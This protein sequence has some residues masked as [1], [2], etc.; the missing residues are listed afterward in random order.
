[1]CLLYA[2]A[3]KTGASHWLPLMH[4]RLPIRAREQTGIYTLSRFALAKHWP[5]VPLTYLSGEMLNSARWYAEGEDPETGLIAPLR[6][7]PARADEKRRTEIEAEFRVLIQYLTELK[8]PVKKGRER[9][10]LMQTINVLLIGI[11]QSEETN[12]LL[13]LQM[14]N[15]LV[16]NMCIT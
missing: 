7:D 4:S 3:L 11:D 10:T 14:L 8:T 1:M 15:L 16:L 13:F 5:D 12:L 9:I 6:A 2:R